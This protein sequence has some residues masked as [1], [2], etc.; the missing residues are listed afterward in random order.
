[1]TYW[2]FKGEKRKI[3]WKYS[4]RAKARNSLTLFLGLE[5]FIVY[6]TLQIPCIDSIVYLWSMMGGK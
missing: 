2:C 5:L 1:M 4:Q 6:D 3:V